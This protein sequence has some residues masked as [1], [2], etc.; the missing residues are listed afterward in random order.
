MASK[1]IL[2]RKIGMTQIFDDQN[3]VEFVLVGQQG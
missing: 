1:G 3:R 2:G